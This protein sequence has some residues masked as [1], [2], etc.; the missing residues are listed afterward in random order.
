VSVHEFDTTQLSLE[1]I[2]AILVEYLGVWSI[3][4]APK[5]YL[6]DADDYKGY[7]VY[8]WHTRD[9]TFILKEGTTKQYAM[10]HGYRGSRAA[11]KVMARLSFNDQDWLYRK[12]LNSAV[13]PHRLKRHDTGVYV[14]FAVLGAS[15]AF[16]SIALGLLQLNFGFQFTLIT[17]IA[18]SLIYGLHRYAVSIEAIDLRFMAISLEY[19][20]TL[21]GLPVVLMILY[22]SRFL[23]SPIIEILF[24]SLEFFFKTLIFLCITIIF[25]FILCAIFSRI[26]NGFVTFRIQKIWSEIRVILPSDEQYHTEESELPLGIRIGRAGEKNMFGPFGIATVLAVLAVLY[27]VWF[28]VIEGFPNLHQDIWIHIAIIPSAVVLIW[29][30]IDFGRVV[31]LTHAQNQFSSDKL[32]Y[33]VDK[34]GIFVFKPSDAIWDTLHRMLSGK[35]GMLSF[36]QEKGSK[37]KKI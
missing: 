12:I 5:D 14:P 37:S 26:L 28:Y 35:S 36:R 4:M 32:E 16:L 21:Y 27:S 8:W 1:Q 17:T 25:C 7:T 29:I 23:V 33:Y 24:P 2:K 6:R 22:S 19:T 20:L 18:T 30:A 15:L 34:D 10:Y 13:D 31:G 11:K 3:T 9:I